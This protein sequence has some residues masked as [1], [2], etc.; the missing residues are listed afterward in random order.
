MSC[1]A[2]GIPFLKNDVLTNVVYSAIFFGS[3]AFVQR[4]SFNKKTA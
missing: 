2:A 3:Y 4:F 1:L